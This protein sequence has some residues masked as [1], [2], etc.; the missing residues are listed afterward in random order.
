[1][2]VSCQPGEVPTI[3]IEGVLCQGR[4]VD[5]AWPEPREFDAITALRNQPWI[6]RWFLD[7]R[8]IAIEANRLWL[9][10]G[11]KRPWE[12]L[13]AVRWRM[14]GRLLGT[15]GWSDWSQTTAS[16]SF[17][18]IMVDR[19]ALR[20]LC[21]GRE[22]C[23][24]RPMLDAIHALRTYVFEEMALERATCV[25]VAGNVLSSRIQSS[26]GFREIGSSQHTRPDGS[27]VTVIESVLTREDYLALRRHAGTAM[28]HEITRA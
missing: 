7:D 2:S 3:P 8:P 13:L 9:T 6:R 14:D 25:H 16:A 23:N 28:P 15:I 24:P 17:G 11:M 27:S 18:R 12:A 22:G 5:L 19:K 10:S 21:R 26:V 20:S 4:Q 1:V